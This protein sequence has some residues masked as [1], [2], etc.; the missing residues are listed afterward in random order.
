MGRICDEL[1]KVDQLKVTDLY[2]KAKADIV[3]FQ[4]GTA[5][6]GCLIA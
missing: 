5:V 6:I 4:Q 1:A 3:G 2:F